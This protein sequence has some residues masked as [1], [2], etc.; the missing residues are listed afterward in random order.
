MGRRHQHG[1]AD[2]SLQALYRRLSPAQGRGLSAHRSAQRRTGLLSGER[3]DSA[4]LSHARSSAVLRQPGGA[5]SYGA[6]RTALGYYRGDWQHRYC[7]GGSGPLRAAHRY[8]KD[9]VRGISRSERTH[10]RR[11][12]AVPNTALSRAAG[13]VYRSG[14][15]R[16]H[17]RG[18]LR[19]RG[20]SAAPECGRGEERRHVLYH[21]LQR[22][23]G[24]ARHQGLHQHLLLS[25]RLRSTGRASGESPGHQA[26]RNHPRRAV[27]LADGRMSGILRDGSRVAGEQRI[28]R[29]GHDGERRLADRYAQPGT[30]PRSRR[31]AATANASHATEE[32]IRACRNQTALKESRAMSE[33]IVTRDIDVEN[34]DILPVYRQHGGYQA[35]E[36]ALKTYQ[37]DDLVELLKKSGL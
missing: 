34:I 23:A 3:W 16:L 36:T 31:E 6:R 17:D 15:R 13:A 5:A 24:Q 29:A 7:P 14:R 28:C 25:A 27:Q 8:R 9:W 30:G 1:G 35:L 19:G 4:A 21:V 33:L 2:S 26:R 12:R 32:P 18:G 37:P 10:A 20:R 11:R 22:T